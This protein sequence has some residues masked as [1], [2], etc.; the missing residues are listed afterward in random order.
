MINFNTMTA[1]DLESRV[2]KISTTIMLILFCRNSLVPAKK[3]TPY[4][5]LYMTSQWERTITTTKQV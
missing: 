5:V 3:V 4:L 2:G 1:D